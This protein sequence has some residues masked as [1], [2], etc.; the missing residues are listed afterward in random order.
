MDASYLGQVFA[1][2]ATFCYLNKK[3]REN[4]TFEDSRCPGALYKK[5]QLQL[6]RN[7]FDKCNFPTTIA[8]FYYKCN[9]F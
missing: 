1:T 9:F 7:F 3:S 6:S 8:T 2:F 4:N 5:L